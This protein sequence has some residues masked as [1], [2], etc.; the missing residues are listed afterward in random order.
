MMEGSPREE[1]VPAL[2]ER[3]YSPTELG[4]EDEPPPL[5]PRN[6][7]W[8]DVEDNDDEVMMTYW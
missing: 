4:L 5:P 7:S 1:E 8:S 3:H 6:Y 2:P